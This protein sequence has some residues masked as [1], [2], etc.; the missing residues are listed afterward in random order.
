MDTY[1]LDP[2]GGLREKQ[3]F[4][5]LGKQSFSL[6]ESVLATKI[7]EVQAADNPP[8]IESILREEFK[9]SVVTGEGNIEPANFYDKTRYVIIWFLAKTGALNAFEKPSTIVRR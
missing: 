7:L 9:I 4:I 3:Y 1:D 2:R 6:G 8:N 5:E